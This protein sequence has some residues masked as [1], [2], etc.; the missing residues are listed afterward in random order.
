[1]KTAL[2]ALFLIFGFFVAG[3]SQA[4]SPR[5]IATCETLSRELDS[6]FAIY[7]LDS[8]HFLI[9]WIG[10]DHH[11]EGH[12]PLF[13][14]RVRKTSFIQMD[15]GGEV[16][17]KDPQ[18]VKLDIDLRSGTGRMEYFKWHGYKSSLFS[19]TADLKLEA[20]VACEM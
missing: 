1:M 18:R 14:E 15:T 6:R 17:A 7:D 11:V 10:S 20:Q 2:N 13:M 16:L 19:R 3:A 12:S 4:E 5:V 8:K 9:A